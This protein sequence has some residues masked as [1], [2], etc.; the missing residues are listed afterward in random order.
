MISVY[1]HIPF[2]NNICSYCDFSKVYYNKDYVDK[3]LNSLKKEIQE[4]Y[5]KKTVKTLYIGGGTPSALSVLEL[6]KL[7]EILKTFNLSNNVEFTMEA[8]PDSLTLEKIKLMK[9]NKVNRVSLGV[10]SFDQNNLNYLNRTHNKKDVLNCINLLKSNNITNINIDL[11]YG[12]NENLNKV[13]KDIDY[14]LKLDIPHISTYS[15]IIEKNTILGNK[16]VDYIDQDLDY[17]MYKYI[18]TTLENNGYI[19]YEISNYAKKG[20]YSKHNLV[21][22]NNLDYYG[23]GLSSVSYINNYRITNTKNLTKYLANDYLF[24]KEYEDKE[25]RMYNEIMLK[26]RTNKGIDLKL[27]KENYNVCLSENASVIDLI[28]N[29]YLIK[30]N[31]FLKINKQYLYISNEIILKIDLSI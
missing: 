12:I 25:T 23:F 5:N 27:F 16:K 31:N 29:H 15:L 19:H 1:I 24:S 10:Q 6:T 11:I 22:W 13:K 4:R 9:T 2:C 17:E 3:Y 21:Y 20:Y 14:F 18:E 26:L 30:E 28:N 8:N 7:F